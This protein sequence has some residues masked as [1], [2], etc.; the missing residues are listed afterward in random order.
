MRG[1]PGSGPRRRRNRRWPKAGRSNI[2]SRW[3]SRCCSERSSISRGGSRAR[4]AAPTT[5]SAVCATRTASRRR[6]SGRRRCRGRAL[7]ELGDVNRG[8]RELEGVAAAH[9][10][11]RSALLRPYYLVLYAGALLAGRKARR[12]TACARRVRAV[13]ARHQSSTPTTPNTRACRRKCFQR[14][15]ARTRPKNHHRDGLEIAHT[16]GAR[17]LELRSARAYANFLAAPGASPRLGRFSSRRTRRSP[18]ATGL[19]YGR[20]R[21]LVEDP[22]PAVAGIISPSPAPRLRAIAR[23]CRS[24]A[25]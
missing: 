20:R 5:S 15:A 8:L 21:G 1:F 18:K 13:C 14:A 3:R 17:W 9:T 4:S 19:R 10:I 24:R 22:E 12:R 23:E 16:Q 2:R 11:T 25:A 6:C 7:V